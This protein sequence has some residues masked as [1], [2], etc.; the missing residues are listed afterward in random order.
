MAETDK[1]ELRKQQLAKEMK[2]GRINS[3]EQV[4]LY[5]APSRLATDLNVAYNSLL[6][7]LENPREFKFNDA[8]Q[9]AEILK[10]E[11]EL[12]IQFITGTIKAKK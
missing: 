7:R 9:L 12:I 3:W 8:Y 2:A 11:P 10:V 6:A 1:I 5:Y 4:L